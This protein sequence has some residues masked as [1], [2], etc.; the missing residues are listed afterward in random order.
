VRERVIDFQASVESIL[1]HV[2]AFGATGSLACI[3]ATWFGVKRAVGWTERHD[4]APGEVAHV[5]NRSIV[6]AAQDGYVGLLE[7]EPL[8]LSAVA[9][10]QSELRLFGARRARRSAA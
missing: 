9:E 6:V 5:H 4:C 7:T 1:L 3:G 2:R 10:L 8:P